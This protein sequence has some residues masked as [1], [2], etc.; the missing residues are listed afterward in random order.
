MAKLWGGGHFVARK[1]NYGA[2]RDWVLLK[3]I[4]IE[5]DAGEMEVEEID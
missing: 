3:Q 1:D 5:L 4:T 2:D